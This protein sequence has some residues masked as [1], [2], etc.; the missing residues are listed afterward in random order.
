MDI[1][2]R[3]KHHVEVFHQ[4]YLDTSAIRTSLIEANNELTQA[5]FLLLETL[6]KVST[7]S[8]AMARTLQQMHEA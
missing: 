8:K 7:E 2:T 1:A 4:T 3:I 6:E 5:E